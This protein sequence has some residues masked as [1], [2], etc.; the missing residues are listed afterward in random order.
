MPFPKFTDLG[1]EAAIA[2]CIAAGTFEAIPNAALVPS[3]AF[4]DAAWRIVYSAAIT[5]R[6][7]ISATIVS[8]ESVNDYIAFHALDRQLQHAIDSTRALSWQ[9]W[10][11]RADISLAYA[12][13]N[14]AYCLAELKRLYVKRTLARLG[15]EFATGDAEIDD[16]CT[17][18][19]ALRRFA[20]RNGQLPSIVGADV[21]CM[22]PPSA[23]PE[24]I[25]GVLHRGSKMVLGG[26]SKSFKTWLLL[27]LAYRTAHGAPWFGF[28]T[29]GG[30][31]LYLNFELP[32]FALEARL[33]ELSGAIALPVPSALQLWNLRGYAADATTLLPAIC[34]EARALN[35]ELIVLDPLYKILGARDENASRDMANLMNMIERLALDTGAAVAF[36]AHFA[37]GNASLKEA[38]DRF[39][40]SGVIGRDPDTIITLT[41][42]EQENAFAVDMIL[43]NFPQQAPFTVRWEHPLMIIDAKLDPAD[44]KKPRS[45][46]PPE[47]TVPDLLETLTEPMTSGDWQ[48]ASD[49]PRRTFYTLLKQARQSGMIFKS[50]LDSKWSRKP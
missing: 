22:N 46:R 49:I 35:P 6:A 21:L 14:A 9:Q 37:K 33:R 48:E 7:E 47:Y 24:I 45:G 26:G 25:A 32:A 12:P 13:E 29:T 2:G 3:E 10:P 17:R 44:L 31:V 38:I 41:Q 43:R 19:E 18:L 11:A 15:A 16:A 8:A 4:T 30:H 20:G 40:G 50:P 42:H 39:S 1:K 27:D 34:A 36:G 28:A 5:L 23:P